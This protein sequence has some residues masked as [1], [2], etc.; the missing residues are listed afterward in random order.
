MSQWVQVTGSFYIHSWEDGIGKRL[1]SFMR[2]NFNRIPDGSEGALDWGVMQSSEHTT[3][4]DFDGTPIYGRGQLHIF[5][6]LR[7]MTVDMFEDGLMDF[8]KVLVSA[9][10]IRAGQVIVDGWSNGKRIYWYNDEWKNQ[11]FNV[12]NIDWDLTKTS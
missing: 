10:P 7:D 6:S 4:S 11:K 1:E 5:G 12:I 3:G 8:L 2:D 9:F